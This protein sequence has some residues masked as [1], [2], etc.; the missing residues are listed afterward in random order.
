[1]SDVLISRLANCRTIAAE[2][3]PAADVQAIDDAIETIQKLRI[4]AQIALEDLEQATSFG[5]KKARDRHAKTLATLRVCVGSTA[6]YKLSIDAAI[7]AAAQA[8]GIGDA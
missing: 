4:S 1:M 7:D 3:L 2:R 5:T 8:R 6:D